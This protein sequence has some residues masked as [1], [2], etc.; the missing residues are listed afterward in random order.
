MLRKIIKKYEENY[1][2]ILETLEKIVGKIFTT[3]TLHE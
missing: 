1:G 3:S 2:E